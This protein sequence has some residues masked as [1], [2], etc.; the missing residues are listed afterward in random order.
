MRLRYRIALVVMVVVGALL[1]LNTIVTDRET[2]DAHA[3]IGQVL[4]L[5]GGALQVREDG[6]RSDPA[7]VLIH[8]WAASMRW[9]DRVVPLL[10][11]GRR[12]IRVDLLGHGGSAKPRTGYSIEAQADRVALALRVLRVKQ[13]LVAGHSA[14]GEVAIALTARHPD[15]VRRL[16][17]IDSKADEDDVNVD[18]KAKLSVTPV[19]GEAFWRV[20]SDGQ[21]RDGLEQAFSNDSFPVPHQFVRDVRRMTYDSYKKSYDESADYVDQGHLA[22]DFK[23]GRAPAMIVF[24][25]SD[26]LVDPT[27]ARRFV[28]LRRSQVA[29]I[30]GAGHSPMVEKPAELSRLMLR[31]DRGAGRRG[32]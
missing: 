9:W 8:G 13:A 5:P 20:S 23:S 2:K 24:G 19:V 30:D 16:V 1:T 26:R 32:R 6:A 4:D 18:F 29:L 10:S 15:L 31:F 27:S 28:A 14:G 21:I 17:V 11:G 12:V 22:R 3:D 7:I 25:R